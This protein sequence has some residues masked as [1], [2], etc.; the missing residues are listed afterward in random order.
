MIRQTVTR[1]GR[2]SVDLE[3]TITTREEPDTVFA[4]ARTVIV[5]YDYTQ[6]RSVPWPENVR[7]AL[8]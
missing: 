8:A 5:W 2:S 1:V 4:K 7:A 6:G 3:L